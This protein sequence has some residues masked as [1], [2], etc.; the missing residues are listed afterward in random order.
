MP[1]ATAEDAVK[2]IVKARA[3]YALSALRHLNFSPS[4]RQTLVKKVI[5][6]ADLDDLGSAKLSRENLEEVLSPVEARALIARLVGKS[7][8]SKE[9]LELAVRLV[10]IRAMTTPE[11]KAIVVNELMFAST[12]SALEFVS[13]NL[14]YLEAS[15][16]RDV[17][18]DYTK[19][20]ARDMCL[21]LTHRNT[22]RGFE[23]F[24]QA[25]VQIFRECAL[26]K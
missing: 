23:Y 1:N 8:S 18:T 20:I 3:S 21:H 2:V 6:D 25:Q 26:G 15:D 12:K 5:A 14:Q 16:V 24:S 4:L 11:R 10:P 7:G 13:D 17:T 9:W 19:T 22:N